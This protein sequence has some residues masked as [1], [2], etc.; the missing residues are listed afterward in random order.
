MKINVEMLTI[1]AVFIATAVAVGFAFAL[2]PNLE[3]ISTVIFL[4]GYIHGKGYGT[5]IGFFS[6]F[7]FSA[8]NPWGTSLAYPVLMLAQIIS[9]G[10]IGLAGGTV[11][12]IINPINVGIKGII[13]FGVS[14]FLLTLFYDFITSIAGFLPLGFSINMMKKVLIAGIPFS[15]VHIFINTLIFIILIPS[16]IKTFSKVSLFKKYLL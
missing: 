11:R 5:L 10:I 13:V 15:L 14:G 8:L 12:F 3:L 16:I 4:G 2:V 6:G 7:L 9:F 1:T